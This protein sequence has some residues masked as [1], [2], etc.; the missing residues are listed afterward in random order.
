MSQTDPLTKIADQ[1]DR[2]NYH[3]LLALD[4]WNSNAAKLAEMFRDTHIASEGA[5]G[6]DYR[7]VG[8]VDARANTFFEKHYGEDYWKDDEFWDKM[9][10]QLSTINKWEK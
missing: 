3:A 8:M 5:K 10:P 2:T 1:I 7:L 4:Q 9:Y 6:K